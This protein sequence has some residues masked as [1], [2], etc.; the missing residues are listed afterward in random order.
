M[1]LAALLACAPH[2]APPAAPADL[3]A[4][5]TYEQEVAAAAAFDQ[6]VSAFE[7]LDAA[8]GRAAMGAVIAE[9]PG[10]R[11]AS[12]A[13]RVLEETAIVGQPAPPLRVDEW[14]QGGPPTG[15]VVLYVFFEVWCPHC[16][17]ELPKIDA[18][19]PGLR[20]RGIET[21]AL[22]RLTRDATAEAVR[23]FA[24]LHGL[25][26]PIGHEDNGAMAEAYQVVGIPAAA[27]VKDGVIVWRGHPARLTETVWESV[28][29]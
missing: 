15:N 12:A 1:L 7:R 14:Y 11:A 28:S 29:K 22:T 9:W 16:Q 5:A 18:A 13:G 25:T 20:A 10:T 17:D 23:A 8:G 24:Q 21:V 26:L 27:I 6:G 19:A 2:P 4:P 3:A